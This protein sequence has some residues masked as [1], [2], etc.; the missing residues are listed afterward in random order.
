[1]ENNVK[2]TIQERNAI[3]E[4][5]L[6]LAMFYAKNYVGCGV[7]LDDLYSMGVEGLIHAA[8]K[9]DPD[10]GY[11]F[12]TYAT[13]WIRQSITRGIAKEGKTIRIPQ[14][15]TDAIRK[16]QNYE[17]EYMRE[18]GEE[19]T[20]DQIIEATGLTAK[21]ATEALSYMYNMVSFDTPVGE[22]GDTTMSNF[23]ADKKAGNPEEILVADERSLAIER[24]LSKLDPKE[25]KVLKYRHGIGIDH[26]MTLEEIANLPEFMVTRERIR[27]IENNAYV[28]IRKSKALSSQLIDFVS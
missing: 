1:M 15:M 28:K 4:A 17:K 2:K 11:E 23:I 12:S 20:V 26:S 3:V 21:K 5:N 14:H 6:K 19:P 22:D 9:F 8:E 27:Q 16:I 13:H 10:L 18:N 25:A 24:V 7:D